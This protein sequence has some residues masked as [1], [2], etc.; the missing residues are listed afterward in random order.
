M[1]W[2][3][4]CSWTSRFKGLKSGDCLYVHDLQWSCILSKLS[5]ALCLRPPRIG[6]R[7]SCDL[8]LDNIRKRIYNVIYLVS[9]SSHLNNMKSQKTFF[10]IGFSSSS[11]HEKR[12]FV[13]F[14]WNSEI[15]RSSFFC[16]IYFHID[17]KIAGLSHQPNK[18]PKENERNKLGGKVKNKFR[19]AKSGQCDG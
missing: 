2:V 6:V 17:W 5:S 16:G 7:P 1:N 10:T 18:E 11:P 9:Y 13:A 14:F 4:S 12:M 8:V 3:L 19:M 15:E